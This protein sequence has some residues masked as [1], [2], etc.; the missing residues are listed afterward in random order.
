MHS[1]MHFFV[2]FAHVFLLL[3]ILGLASALITRH[4]GT[5]TILLIKRNFQRSGTAL[6]TVEAHDYHWFC[7]VTVG[8]QEFPLMIDTGSSVLLVHL[9]NE[10]Q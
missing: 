7:N 2:A 4:D 1:T 9:S 3:V 10:V 5:P 8:D 6:L